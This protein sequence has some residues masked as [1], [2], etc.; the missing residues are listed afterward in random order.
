MTLNEEFTL[1]K[2]KNTLFEAISHLATA[3]G[4]LRA[5]LKNVD[6]IYSLESKDFPNELQERWNDV[7][8][9]LTRFP[10]ENKDIG[11]IQSNLNRMK[12]STASKISTMIVEL[13]EEI[14]NF[15]E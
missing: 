14:S 11:I 6:A 12:N 13:Y 2:I 1:N 8:N 5:R 10:M 9:L 3:E 15:K 7:T 4:D